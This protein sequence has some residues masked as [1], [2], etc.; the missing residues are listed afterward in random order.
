MI[1]E[2]RKV[3]ILG[4][5]GMAVF[6]S[7]VDEMKAQ[8]EISREEVKREEIK[9]T[10][11][12]PVLVA[13]KAR[14][15]VEP[16]AID[17]IL[18]QMGLEMEESLFPA[19]ELYNSWNTEYVKAYAGVSVPDSFPVNVA[20]FV[21]PVEGRVT[22]PFGP[23]RKRFHYGTDI[24]LQVGDTVYAAFE[25]KVRVKQY[26]RR[27]YGYYLVL[28]HPNGLETVYGH[29]SDFLVEQDE[30]VAAGQPI[31]LGGNTG[32]ST[33]PHLHF[34]FRFLGNA[35]NPTEIVD[36]DE[37]CLKDDNYLFVKGESSKS[38]ISNKY[39]ARGDSKI[40]YHRIKT[41]DTLGTI[42]RKHGVSVDKLC[43]LN[44]IKSSTTLRAGKAI[45]VS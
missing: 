40:K 12:K 35:I 34:E 41:G 44:K 30:N 39:A 1:K 14:P 5:V 9:K 31:A 36:F 45:R 8:N 19:D 3:S 17:S 42:A 4:L 11:T 22:S 18:M 27:G 7:S 26:E 25:G 21:M 13:D 10:T 37:L 33:G 15:G 32:R 24:K 23:R 38:S 29:L 16:I 2:L 20:G 28:R 6:F 43:K